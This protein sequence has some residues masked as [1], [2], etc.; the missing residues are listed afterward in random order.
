MHN[1]TPPDWR[2]REVAQLQG[3]VDR[4]NGLLE[5]LTLLG[6]AHEAPPGQRVGPP[7][8]EGR[9]T[10]ERPRKRPRREPRG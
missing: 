5:A 8:A 3:E 6:K 7:T 2:T 9:V 10:G 4:L 1:E